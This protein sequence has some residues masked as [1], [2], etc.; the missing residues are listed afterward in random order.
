MM[1]D[2][3]PAVHTAIRSTFP[4]TYPM[5]CTFHISQNLIKK[6]QKLLRNKFHEFLI[7]FYAIRNTL[8]KISFES[9]WKILITQYPEI[10]QYLTNTLYN[11]KEAWVHPWTC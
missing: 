3:D 11:T 9:K 7:Q 5:H 2:A 4:F 1:T 10:E 8:N 6:V